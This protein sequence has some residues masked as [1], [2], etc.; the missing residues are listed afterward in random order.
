MAHKVVYVIDPNEVIIE[1]LSTLLSTYDI[2][3]RPF[4][5]ITSFM[6]AYE[7]TKENN[8][9]LLIEENLPNSSGLSLLHQLRA[10]DIELP[11]IVYTNIAR[12]DIRDKALKLGAIDVIEKPVVNSLLMDLLYKILNNSKQ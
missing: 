4:S 12:P 11:A 5:D 9:C 7:S 10:R 3:I 1:A 8:G 6:E 2:Q